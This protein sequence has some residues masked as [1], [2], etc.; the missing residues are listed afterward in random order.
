M[1]DYFIS[2]SFDLLPSDTTYR[3]WTVV[4]V[5]FVCCGVQA[6]AREQF[7]E[8]AKA[9]SASSIDDEQVP[10]RDAVESGQTIGEATT[11]LQFGADDGKQG[12]H[13]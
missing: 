8:K 11:D 1:R 13:T 6:V 3:E 4:S 9:E 7:V 12:N 5:P 10:F 2:V